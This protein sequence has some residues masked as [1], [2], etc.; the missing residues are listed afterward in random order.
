MSCSNEEKPMNSRREEV[1]RYKAIQLGFKKDC[2]KLLQRFADL[3]TF[4][5]EK[6]AEIWQDMAFSLVFSGKSSYNEF[7]H[8]T[9]VFLFECKKYHI[10]TKNIY[11]KTGAFYLMYGLYYKQPLIGFVK[12]RVTY[13]EF[14]KILEFVKE[15]K[16]LKQMQ[17]LYTYCKMM[18]DNVFD[19]V[20]TQHIVAPDLRHFQEN[21]VMED[22]T[23]QQEPAEAI[24]NSLLKLVDN[25][26]I[27]LINSEYK[28]ALAEY[29]E[30][31]QD[32][33]L[34]VFDNNILSNIR[35][36]LSQNLQSEPIASTSNAKEGRKSAVLARRKTA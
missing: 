36:I 35:N 29:K 9:E 15:M 21:F 3:Q 12:I 11:I 31:N 27:M 34:M 28:K 26:D 33:K 17:P 7:R 25:R 14:A 5:Y 2:E 22:N 16:K 32:S 10:F 6:F 24:E 18:A 4:S 13:D 20:Y 8:Y 1:K 19:F 30:T 23:F